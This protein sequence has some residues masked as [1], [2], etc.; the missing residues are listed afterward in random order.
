MTKNRIVKMPTIGFVVTRATEE[1]GSQTVEAIPLAI[2]CLDG[3][4]IGLSMGDDII[5]VIGANTDIT[6]VFRTADD[7]IDEHIGYEFPDDKD[8]NWEEIFEAQK[9]NKEKESVPET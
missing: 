6:A 9:I 1:D 4:S 7:G 5:G 2:G 3:D 8:K